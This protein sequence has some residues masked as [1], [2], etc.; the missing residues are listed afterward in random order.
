MIKTAPRIAVDGRHDLI[1]AGDVVEGLCD[2]LEAGL[3]GSP[4]KGTTYTINGFPVAFV[5]DQFEMFGFKNI[6]S[7]LG[8]A[9]HLEYNLVGIMR[10]QLNLWALPVSDREIRIACDL[11]S[12]LYPSADF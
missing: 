4:A 7:D 3:L 8:L 6:V 11:E 5:Y 1:G 2:A 9:S 10:G 12:S